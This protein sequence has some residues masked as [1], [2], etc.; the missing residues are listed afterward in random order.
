[1]KRVLA[2]L[3]CTVCVLSAC[4]PYEDGPGISFRAK[5]ARLEGDWKVTK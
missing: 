5:K 2:L 1:M 3:I 4:S